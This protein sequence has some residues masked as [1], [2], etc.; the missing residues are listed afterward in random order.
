MSRSFTFRAESSTQIPEAKTSRAA[1][2]GM[3]SHTMP[4]SGVACST[5]RMIAIA[6]ALIEK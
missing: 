1:I 2:A 3:S 5:T 6:T 4:Q